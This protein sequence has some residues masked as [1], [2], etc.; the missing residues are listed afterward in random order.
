MAREQSRKRRFKVPRG[1]GVKAAEAL[2]LAPSHCTRVINGK[3]EGGPTLVKWLEREEKGLPHP[4]ETG[5]LQARKEG[6][7]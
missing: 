6:L 7:V 4:G 3:R 2:G 5:Y 1:T